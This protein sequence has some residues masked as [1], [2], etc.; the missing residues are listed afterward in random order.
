MKW[1][2]PKRQ[3]AQNTTA[4]RHLENLINDILW[5]VLEELWNAGGYT[6]LL[7]LCL[8]SRRLYVSTVPKLYRII[9]LDFSRASHLRLLFRLAQPDSHL[10]SMIRSLGIYNI[11]NQDTRSLENLAAVL[12]GLTHLRRFCCTDYY[13]GAGFILENLDS[14]FP[15]AETIVRG[16]YDE[17][18][19]AIQ[20]PSPLWHILTH[21][22]GSL[23]TEFEFRPLSTYQFYDDLKKNII[24]LLIQNRAL[25]RLVISPNI[26][27]A[28]SYPD[29]LEHIQG[30]ML[31]KLK[32][33]QI[34]NV[35]LPIFSVRELDLWAEQGGWEE[36]MKLELCHVQYVPSFIGRTPKLNELRITPRRHYDIDLVRSHL[37][38]SN[39]EAPF[40]PLCRLSFLGTP[41]TGS[42]PM[43]RRV[44][45][46]YMLRRLPNI[47]HLYLARLRFEA[48]SPGLDLDTPSA[49]D[50]CD[51]RRLCPRLTNLGL[52][53]ALSGIWAKWP[54]KVL[55]EL[56]RFEQPLKLRLYTHHRRAGWVINRAAVIGVM[57]IICRERKRLSLP[58]YWPFHICFKDVRPWDEMQHHYQIPDYTLHIDGVSKKGFCKRRDKAHEVLD[59]LNFDELKQKRSKQIARK[60]G[61]DSKGYSAEIK[62]RLRDPTKDTTLY[63]TLV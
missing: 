25:R 27:S 31:P 14:R 11:S 10:P 4:A 46:W 63:D 40:G 15:R 48:G 24:T 58:Y 38:P 33:L 7:T 9:V 49:Q 29:M 3:P 44:V 21:S 18:A 2:K 8:V 6:D 1:T 61:I 28:K 17:L 60:I 22:A 42:L 41:S 57:N 32:E 59:R 55:T 13:N 5:L 56:A 45:P 36:L 23:L 30:H 16:R 52:D 39:L 19:A 37:A 54:M 20:D 26:M 35:Q 34:S 53:I 47:T 62:R 43:N 12:S 50:I 51:I